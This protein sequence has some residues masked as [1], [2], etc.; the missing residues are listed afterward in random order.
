MTKRSKE[1]MNKVIRVSSWLGVFL[2]VG[3]AACIV[4][5]NML[6][7]EVD[8]QGMLHE[9]FF[10]IPLFWLFL[11]FSLIAGGVNIFARIAQ[12]K[13]KKEISQ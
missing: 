9:P 13:H 12:T 7:A 1:K 11:M 6:G 5:F 8:S 10:L 4:T 3:A 2:F